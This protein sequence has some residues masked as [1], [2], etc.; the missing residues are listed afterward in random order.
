MATVGGA[1]VNVDVLQPGVT[2]SAPASTSTGPSIRDRAAMLLADTPDIQEQD[3]FRELEPVETSRSPRE[4]RK[5]PV[6]AVRRRHGDNGSSR[7]AREPKDIPVPKEAKGKQEDVAML[8]LTE[9][10]T[11]TMESMG[12][13]QMEFMSNMATMMA[14]MQ[15][16]FSAQQQALQPARP[17]IS[18]LDNS[19]LSIGHTPSQAPSSPWG[20]PEGATVVPLASPSFDAQ[21]IAAKVA[22]GVASALVHNEERKKAEA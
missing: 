4:R 19:Q 7:D 11:N 17:A 16:L 18:P 12:R 14:N 1:N 6:I 2:A 3:L 9:T 21:E 5:A 10:C 22:E 20:Q 15:N 13:A 8:K